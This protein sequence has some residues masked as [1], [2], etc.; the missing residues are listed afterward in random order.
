ML[1]EVK[2]VMIICEF[3]IL[4]ILY[5]LQRTFF[6]GS[7]ELSLF[8]GICNVFLNVADG[9]QL[10]FFCYSIQSFILQSLTPMANI[11]PRFANFD[12]CDALQPYVLKR[13]YF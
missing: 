3:S 2:C 9:Q 7:V 11:I 6:T 1:S 10:L 4:P 5:F 13:R 12:M 8:L